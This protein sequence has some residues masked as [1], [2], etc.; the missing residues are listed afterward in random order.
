MIT[1][2]FNGKFIEENELVLPIEERGHNFGD[3]IY[4]V[5]RIHEGAPFYF[6]EHLDRIFMSA[7]AIRL[8]IGYD[9]PAFRALLL[10]IIKKNGGSNLDLYL[11]VTRGIAKRNHTF[12]DCPSSLSVI[13]RPSNPSFGSQKNGA[14][15]HPDER[16]S[17]CYIKS[18][19]LLPNILANQLAHEKGLIEAI[20]HKDGFVT[21]GTRTSVMMVKNGEIWATPLSKQIL[22]SITRM[23]A[24]EAAQ[25]VGI[26]F[27]EKKFTPQELL[28]ADEIFLAGTLSEILPI[29]QVEDTLINQGKTGEIT[30]KL[31][32]SFAEVKLEDKAKFLVGV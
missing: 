29:H 27:V 13:V 4:D 15:F 9:R 24:K 5:I 28:D 21:E 25:K 22:S 7:E 10:D 30:A 16:W 12:P 26:P 18:L 3:G 17:N 32:E 2:F 20:L 31:Q 8:E 11:Q 14:M 6:E 19:N 1:T 23:A